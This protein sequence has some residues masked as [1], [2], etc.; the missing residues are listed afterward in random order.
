[1]K[2]IERGDQEIDASAVFETESLNYFLV[3]VSF[4]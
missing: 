2:I 1:M 3:K 4:Y